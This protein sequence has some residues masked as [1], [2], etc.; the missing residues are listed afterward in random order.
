MVSIVIGQP[1]GEGVERMIVR[2]TPDGR[3][4]RTDAARYLGVQPRTLAKWNMD[5]RGPRPV[6]IGPRCFYWLSD[7]DAFIQQ[8]K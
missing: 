5:G 1:E 4:T 8:G 2:Q 3:L 6:K 7:L